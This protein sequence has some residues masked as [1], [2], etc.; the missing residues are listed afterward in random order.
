MIRTKLEKF[1]RR[2]FDEGA[3]SIL[4]IVLAESE[5]NN[6]EKANKYELRILAKNIRDRLPTVSLAKRNL[7]FAELLKILNVDLLDTGSEKFKNEGVRMHVETEHAKVERFVKQ[8]DKSLTKYEAIFNLFWLRAGEAEQSG[9]N[10]DDIMK[11]TQK[12]LIGVKNDLE[13]TREEILI[14]Y[15]LLEKNKR[16]LQTNFHFHAGPSLQTKIKER[17]NIEL[18]N[19]TI[20]KNIIE[21][22]WKEVDK[23]YSQFKQ[24]FLESMEMDIEFKKSGQNDSELIRQTQTKMMKLWSNL[25]KSYK[26]FSK[27][28]DESKKIIEE[29]LNYLE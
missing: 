8:V 16:K 25:E 23:T 13:K 3:D 17:N 11:I 21:K 4:E 2:E 9:M 22:F 7:L 14:E 6:L 29:N 10:H 18:E 19:K 20:V 1:L 26:I 5:V 15:H 28:M 27:E 12:A 24:I